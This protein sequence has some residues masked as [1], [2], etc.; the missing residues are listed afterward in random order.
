MEITKVE[1][2]Q[3]EVKRTERGWAG[4]FCASDLCKFRR[5]TLLECGEI[6]V[7][8]ST[9]GNYH[10]SQGRPDHVGIGRDYETYA[11]HVDPDTGD[12]KDIDV[13]RPVSFT[14][15]GG[16]LVQKGDKYIDLKANDMHE[17]VVQE[18]TERLQRGET[19]KSNWEEEA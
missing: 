1:Q 18:L 19:L 13:E 6:K 16:Y 2:T 7:V 14:S 17:A 15:P 8:V 3:K 9:V 10:D 11:W 4:H 5:N 12:Y